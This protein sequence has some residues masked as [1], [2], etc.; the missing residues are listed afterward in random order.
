MV[1]QPTGL[2]G[3]VYNMMRSA[4]NY[5]PVA[6]AYEAAVTAKTVGLTGLQIVTSAPLTCVGVSYL[7]GIFFAYFG[8]VAGDNS[9]GFV[10]NATS[11]VLTRP[12]RMIE[13]TL[14]GLILQPIS[15]LTGFPL[16]LNNTKELLVRKGI[17]ITDY[18]KISFAFERVSTSAA[19]K[20][21]RLKQ[22]INDIKKV[23]KNPEM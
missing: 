13:V 15:E 16:I 2:Q 10:L 14:N 4:Q 20:S 8:S 3:K 5:I 9:L 12:M 1:V 18:A 19:K 11:Y 6:Y 7:G 21:K 17:N 23:F 22:I